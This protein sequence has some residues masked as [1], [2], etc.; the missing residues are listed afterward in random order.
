MV[1]C[2]SPNC[3]IPPLG[4]AGNFISLSVVKSFPFTVHRT[5]KV[6]ELPSQV[7]REGRKAFVTGNSSQLHFWKFRE[8]ARLWNI[9]IKLTV[10]NFILII[11]NCKV[12]VGKS[13]R[14]AWMHL[15]TVYTG[16]H[17][18][19]SDQGV[20]SPPLICTNEELCLISRMSKD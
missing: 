10:Q 19:T 15:R 13:S 16:F 17:K 9:H 4:R 7:S 14:L 8:A 11:E 18:H 20:K 6:E 5:E 3:W 1:P 2:H 12:L